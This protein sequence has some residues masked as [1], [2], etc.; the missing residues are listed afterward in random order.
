MAD[1]SDMRVLLA[2][3]RRQGD[4]DQICRALVNVVF[5]DD[6]WEWLQHQCIELVSH[7]DPSVREVAVTC[8]G[9]IARFH[10]HLDRDRIDALL[11][12]LPREDRSVAGVVARVD[13]GEVVE[14]ARREG[15]APS[16]CD[17]AGNELAAS[18]RTLTP[19]SLQRGRCP[20]R[21]RAEEPLAAVVQPSLTTWRWATRWRWIVTSLFRESS[22]LQ[23]VLSFEWCFPTRASDLTN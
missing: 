7:A 1:R 23:S 19:R 8:F 10:H 11:A 15:G 3:A 4:A 5:A 20:F 14:T 13:L 12:S 9:H 2:E 16:G 21:L 18:P 17:V 22:T 6:S